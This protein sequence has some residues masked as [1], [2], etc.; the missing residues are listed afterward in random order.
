VT[1]V[2]LHGFTGDGSTMADLAGRLSGFDVD[3]PD[4]TGHGDGPHPH[5]GEAYRVEQMADA[6]LARYPEP[7]DLVGY[8][9]GG[10]VA[11]AC[12]CRS[13][14]SI[15]SLSLIGASA[16]LAEPEQRRSRI[17]ADEELAQL[18]EHD[19]AAFVDRWM[20]NPLFATQ[21]RLGPDVLA[22]A[23]RQRL[24]NDPAA[25]AQSL[26]AAGTGQM[27]PLHDQLATVELPVGLIVGADDT[28]FVSIANEL[29][30]QL[31]DAVV[32]LIPD[33][34][35]AAHLEQPDAVAAAILHTLG[36]S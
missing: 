5:D 12:A 7:F 20:A 8:S 9:L 23:R 4:L 19:L 31:P 16:G 24:G 25:L 18:I 36:R 17:E 10:R 34:G 29:A 26:R 6:L 13:P 2:V 33:A 27:I 30:Q 1:V 15:R 32:H 14:K 28:K 35:H 11:L 21:Q 22:A 3:T